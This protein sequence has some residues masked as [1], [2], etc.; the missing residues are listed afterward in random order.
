MKRARGKMNRSDPVFV[1]QVELLYRNAPLAYTTTLINGAILA[2]IQSEHIP[3][4]V[5][6]AWYV[7][8]VIVTGVRAYVARRHALASPDPA[9]AG[10]WNLAYFA[11]AGAAGCVW[12]AAG[13][14][15]FPPDSIAHQVFVAFVL[16]GMSAGAVSVL[17]S[18]IETC[19][20][21][22]LPALLPLAIRYLTLHTPL[23]TAMGVMTVI[24]LVA[25]SVSAWNFHCAIRT[26]L[27][28]RFD[29][30]DLEAEIAR[31]VRAEERLFNEKERL[32]TTLRSIGE[33]VVLID[34]DGRVE[35][36]NPAAERLFER[37]RHDAAGHPPEEVFECFDDQG[38]RS[39]TALEEALK[40]ATP[41]RK[42]SVLYGKDN[43]RYI[44]E[45]LA[46]PLLDRDDRLVGAV[47]VFRDV[48]EQHQLTEQ[49][50]HA[51]DHDV[52]TGLPNRNL[53][54]ER[55]RQ[56]VARAQ[57][58]HETFGLLFID[59][60]DFKA[61]N[62]TLGH[63]SGDSLLVDVARRLAECV[64]EEDTIARLGGD[65]FVVLLDGPA[66]RPEV[67]AI[68]AKIV[69]RLREPF[70]LETRAAAI[71]ASIGASLYPDDG[72]D[73]ES[74]LGA[75]DA[76]MYREKHARNSKK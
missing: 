33:G 21:F 14:V 3:L 18:R 58:K 73:V 41:R 43:V 19:I 13:L 25:L 38:W 68:A 53:L 59:L 49:L 60:D 4:V 26:S 40:S 46:T 61:V 16:A 28:L 27:R 63:A 22:M 42:R 62:D 7:S 37:R 20:A 30:Q 70:Q 51:A 12:G 44:V 55:T 67:E 47:S 72:H 65:E 75:A 1:E 23:Q 15:L 10:I 52:L 36:F 2:Y 50:I 32:Q 71:G 5:L 6:L 24:F 54:K 66:K 29:K 64:R 11:G 45:E 31:R 39:P 35:D 9:R 8:L 56:A 17:A 76:A 34:A 48:T 69:L 57:R 74:L